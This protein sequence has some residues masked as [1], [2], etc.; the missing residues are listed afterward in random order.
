MLPQTPVFFMNANAPP[1]PPHPSPGT[2]QKQNK[3]HELKKQK[4]T[5]VVVQFY[6][7][8]YVEFFPA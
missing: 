5:Q 7:V 4:N 8:Y 6:S 3:K 1:P 2:K